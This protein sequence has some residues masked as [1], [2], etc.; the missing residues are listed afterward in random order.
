[1]THM[2][3]DICRYLGSIEDHTISK[4]HTTVYT[5]ELG[6]VSAPSVP[7]QPCIHPLPAPTLSLTRTIEAH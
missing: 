1:M 5:H 3:N 4:L 2:G 6:L 7:L